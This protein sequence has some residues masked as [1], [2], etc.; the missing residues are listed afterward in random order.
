M[1]IK[2]WQ[3]IK[4]QKIPGCCCCPDVQELIHTKVNQGFHIN[5]SCF[6]LFVFDTLIKFFLFL[7]RIFLKQNNIK[8]VHCVLED[9]LSVFTIPTLF[10]ATICPPI[11]ETFTVLNLYCLY[12]SVVCTQCHTHFLLFHAVYF[13]RYDDICISCNGRNVSTVRD[14]CMILS[15]LHVL[16]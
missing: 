14:Y 12:H 9:T 15:F 11:I 13:G 5:A 8:T 7:W 2:A 16:A 4:A 1:V 3:I 10:P 6:V